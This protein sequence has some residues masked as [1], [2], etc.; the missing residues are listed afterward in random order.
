[1]SRDNDIAFRNELDGLV[2]QHPELIASYIIG[3]SVTADSIMQNAPE[4]KNQTVYISGPEPMV[5]SIGEDLKASGVDL[6]Q[7]WFP[8]YDESSF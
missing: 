2:E 1:Y 7:D 4:Y 6:K 3:Q 5:D 8:G